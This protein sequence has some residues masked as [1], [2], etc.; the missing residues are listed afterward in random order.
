MKIVFWNAYHGFEKSQNGM[1][2]PQQ[3]KNQFAA[4][5]NE[6]Q[7]DVVILLEMSGFDHTKL[8]IYASRWGHAHVLL[9]SGRFP[10]AITSRWLI[11]NPFCHYQNMKNG[12]VMA[13]IQQ[14]EIFVTHI[15]TAKYANRDLES[16]ELLSHLIPLIRDNRSPLIF[17]DLNS[18]ANT[19]L[20]NAMQAIGLQFVSENETVD[21]IMHPHSVP[22]FS[23]IKQK[24]LSDHPAI[25]LTWPAIAEQNDKPI[26]P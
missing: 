19:P 14:Q 1:L 13:K 16:Q 21:Y 4:W 25:I 6:Q 9:N 10:I 11:Q 7:A 20:V 15:P 18:F 2:P 26:D 17:A 5:L 22:V 12:F 3:R 8:S 23:T 24:K